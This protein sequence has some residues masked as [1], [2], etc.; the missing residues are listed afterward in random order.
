MSTPL[1]IDCDTG[2]DDALALLYACASPEAEIVG[3]GCV[4]GNVE[5]PDVVRNTQAVLEL[6]GRGDIEV[7]AGRSA[8]IARPLRT[9]ADTH[10]PTGLGHARLPEPAGTVSTRDAAELFI[11]EARARP[12]ALTLVTLAAFQRAVALGDR[13]P[14]WPW[15][16]NANQICRVCC[17][18]W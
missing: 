2:I 14:T 1:L 18:G 15:P 16:W 13:F 4:A 3:V 7:A 11:D 12:G 8:P 17:D 9:A 5:L 6:A 10:G